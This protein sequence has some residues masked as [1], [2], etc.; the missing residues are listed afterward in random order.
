MNITDVIAGLDEILLVLS[1][2]Y[3]SL[4]ELKREAEDN[5]NDGSDYDVTLINIEDQ[6]QKIEEAKDILTWELI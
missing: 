5:G 1:G 6:M 2:K 4:W 3:D